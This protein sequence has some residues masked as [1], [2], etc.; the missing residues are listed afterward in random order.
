MRIRKTCQ[1]VG[2]GLRWAKPLDASKGTIFVCALAASSLVPFARAVR[3]QPTAPRFCI[4]CS[5]LRAP[6]MTFATVG[7]C[8]QPIERDLRDRSCSVSAGHLVEGV[9][10]LIEVFVLRRAGPTSFGPVLIADRLPLGQRLAAPQ[11][12][13]STG[14]SRAGLQTTAPTF[15]IEAERHEFPLVFASDRTNSKLDGRRNGSG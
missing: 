5:S 6:M 14:P 4:S 11:F 10:H 7:R 8:K 12:C 15:L 2:N 9:D 3:V 13:R 1:A